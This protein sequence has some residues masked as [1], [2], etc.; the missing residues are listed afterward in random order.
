M[1]L[2]VATPAGTNRFCHLDGLMDVCDGVWGG[3]TL[4][5]RLEI[6][7]D[8]RVGAFAVAGA[9][10]VLLV[11]YGT[12]VTL[13]D[14]KDTGAGAVWPEL[15]LFPVAARW[16]VTLLSPHF[17]TDGSRASERL[18]PPPSGPS[19]HG[20][21][22]ADCRPLCRRCRRQSRHRHTGRRIPAGIAA[23]T[24]PAE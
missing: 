5:R 20:V 8:S 10:C 24:N 14:S 12:L 16:T 9:G 17:L 18:S 13:L 22:F 19:R 2:I 15:L 1:A 7:H 21:G 23:G 4:E 6:M 11:K 3:P